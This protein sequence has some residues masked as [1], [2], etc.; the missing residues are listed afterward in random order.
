M[1]SLLNLLAGIALL[2]WGTYL[3]R[4]SML[5][6]YGA[7]L[8]RFLTQ[9]ANNRFVALF[10]GLA[11]TGLLQSSTATALLTTSFSGSG[12][13]ATHSALAIMLGA[14]VGTALAA[15]F[16]SRDLTAVSSLL[17]FVGVVVFL[18]K[19]RT[20]AE[21]WGRFAIGLGLM[22]HALHMVVAATKP[23]TQNAGAKALFGSIS[24]DPLLDVVVAAAFAVVAY[25]SLAV[26]LLTSALTASQ[27]IG[28]DT[29]IALVLGANIGSGVLAVLM[30]LKAKPDVRR[31]P[32]GNLLFKLL[33]AALILPLLSYFATA[34]SAQAIA[35]AFA[36]I[37]FHLAFNVALAIIGIALVQ[38]MARLTEKLLPR[39]S[40][41]IED[42]AQPKYLDSQTL[43][44]PSLA[45]ANASREALRVGDFVEQMLASLGRL[46]RDQDRAAAEYVK[47]LDDT[48]DS[49]YKAIKLYLTKVSRT[50]MTEAE[51]RRW[52]DIIS[53]TIN[54]EQVGDI[55][56]K[57]SNDV[58][59]KNIDRQRSFSPAGLAELVDLHER[60][61]VNLGLAMNVFLNNDVQDAQRLVE[62]KVKFR[63]LEMV[64]Y[65]RHLARLADQTVQ[66]LETSSLHLD[67]MRDLKRI[68]SHFCS[69]AYPILEAAGVLSESRLRKVSHDR[70]ITVMEAQRDA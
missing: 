37:L 60:L 19:Q 22:M 59:Q 65:E 51:S 11:V 28:L 55:I 33:G 50:P 32:L 45:L 68:N 48:V 1:T 49:L 69:V 56:E 8:R 35:P 66:S 26:V 17:I 23:L 9:S 62:E 27:V 29:A 58:V 41:A 42:S 39:Q 43:T 36:V 57:S 38:P 70:D 3:V 67:L 12:F 18:S 31:V 16:L 61:R 63:E 30:T 46:I 20:L 4:S 7:E 64:N 2:V 47:N 53:F 44:T 52:T 40:E 15:L 25:S 13:I 5:R 24:G 21:H 34:L 14:D 54:L 10:A 6:V